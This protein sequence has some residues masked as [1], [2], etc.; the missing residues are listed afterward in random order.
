[1]DFRVKTTARAKRDLDQILERLLTE[2]AGDKGL[3]WFAGMQDAISSLSSLPSRCP[4]VPENSRFSSETR[5]LLY[6]RRHVY[7]ILFTIRNDI[8]VVF[9]YPAWSPRR[10]PTVVKLL[11]DLLFL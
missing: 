11:S 7:R 6:G 1:M 2:F 5:Q 9:P 8:V 4:L 10:S 3:P